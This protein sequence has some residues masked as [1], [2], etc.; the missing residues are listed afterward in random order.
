MGKRRGG[1]GGRGGGRGGRGP[2]HTL[3]SAADAPSG[4]ERVREGGDGDCLF[5]AI[6]RQ[7][8]GDTQLAS[9]ARQQLCD[10]MEEHL[11]PSAIAAGRSALMDMHRGMVRDQREELWAGDDVRVLQYVQRMRR[12]GEWGTGLEALCSAYRYGR[13]VNVWSPEGFSELRPPCGPEGAASAGGGG[14]SAP[15]AIYLQH[16]GRNHWDS[17]RP[18]PGGAAGSGGRRRPAAARQAADEE[19]EEE[20][21]ALALALSIVETF[22]DVGEEERAARRRVA[23]AAAQER[24]LRLLSR[25]CSGPAAPKVVP[26]PLPQQPQQQP[27]QQPEQQL[28]Q[29]PQLPPSEL[30]AADLTAAAPSSAAAAVADD[31]AGMETGGDAAASP[32][33]RRRVARTAATAQPTDGSASSM[34]LEEET[35]LAIAMASTEGPGLAHTSEDRA[36]EVLEECLAALRRVGLTGAEA[37]EALARCNGNV[38]QV[39]DLYGIDW[40]SSG[41]TLQVPYAA[42]P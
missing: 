23:A 11:T 41:R 35:I 17:L 8:L 37:A 33:E 28:Q 3:G 24:E 34:D 18:L 26:K 2:G 9:Q 42:L 1:G 5:H 7:A 40:D 32:W 25:G 4:F 27:E 6:A 19:E 36:S 16:N 22:P 10:W 14:G 21:V 30:P 12:Q 15:E 38:E 20:A 29:H 13:P 39:K 31:A